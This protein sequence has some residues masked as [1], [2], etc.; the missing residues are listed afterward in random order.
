MSVVRT[1]DDEPPPSAKPSELTT[2]QRLALVVSGALAP[3]EVL[4]AED[5]ALDFAYFVKHKITSEALASVEIGPLQLKQR[6]A[7]KPAQLR[8]LGYETLDLCDSAFCAEAVAAFGAD[9]I[10]EEFLV[11]PND[12][13][14]LAGT[15]AVEQLGLDVGTLLCMC[16]GDFGLAYQVLL[17]CKPRG[18][19]LNGVAPLTLLESGLRKSQLISLGYV[20]A[21][22]AEQT[23]ASDDELA[24]LG[25]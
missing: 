18:Q 19:C 13:L 20:R 21:S 8:E 4:S 22:I 23:R 14:V 5:A 16:E 25:F 10:V 2:R 17:A 15:S 7:T 12:A 6:G 1:V 9:A 24:E 11:T 3:Q